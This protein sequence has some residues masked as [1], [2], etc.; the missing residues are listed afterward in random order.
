[1]ERVL[2]GRGAAG[3]EQPNSSK[4]LSQYRRPASKKKTRAEKAKRA[5]LARW[6]QPEEEAATATAAA[7]AAAAAGGDRAT[8]WGELCT[9]GAM[10]ATTHAVQHLLAEGVLKAAPHAGSRRL[11]AVAAAVLATEL[12]PERQLGGAEL[13]RLA[14]GFARCQR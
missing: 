7:A 6:S 5:A 14:H 2:R 8:L 4:V 11:R 10:A 1:M 12:G 13:I 3:A 9:L